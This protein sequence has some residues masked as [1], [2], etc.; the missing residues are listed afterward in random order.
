M[1]CNVDDLPLSHQ[2][3]S[4]LHTPLYPGSIE[5]TIDSKTGVFCN[6]V[7]M[8]PPPSKCIIRASS[9]PPVPLEIIWPRYRVKKKP[10]S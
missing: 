5:N 9:L 4:P 8:T 7:E 6:L 1:L 3:F 2:G 10:L